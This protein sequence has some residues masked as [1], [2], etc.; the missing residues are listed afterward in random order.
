MS[1]LVGKVDR[2]VR[3]SWITQKYMDKMEERR[4]WKNST[5]KKEGR[6]TED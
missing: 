5:R 6:T 3:K 4:K 2:K 1:D